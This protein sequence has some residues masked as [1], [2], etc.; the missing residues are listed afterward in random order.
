MLRPGGLK[1][2]LFGGYAKRA[3]QV[4]CSNQGGR[5]PGLAGLRMLLICTFGI[6]EGGGNMKNKVALVAGAGGVVG[7]GLVEHLTNL[8]EWDVSVLA[9]SRYKRRVE[10]SFSRCDLL[11]LN[12]CRTS[13]RPRTRSPTCFMPLTRS[14]PT[15]ASRS[16]STRRC[17][18]T[19]SA[20]RRRHVAHSLSTLPGR[21]E[22]KA[23][24]L[25][26]RAL[27]NPIQGNRS[28]RRICA[29]F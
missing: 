8:A 4:F 12:D 3:N 6:R 1:I 15:E 9:V 10:L 27:Q 23:V 17:C 28:H 19:W 5:K 25:P 22:V 13:W 16:R 7:R 24:R 2:H 21:K 11:D 20:T 26:I 29:D 14:V 18:G